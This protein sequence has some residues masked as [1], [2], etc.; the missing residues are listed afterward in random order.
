MIKELNI[1]LGMHFSV[2]FSMNLFDINYVKNYLHKAMW[3]DQWRC[4]E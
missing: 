3:C 2:D 1:I 4:M